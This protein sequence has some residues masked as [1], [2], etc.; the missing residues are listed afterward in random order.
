M[1]QQVC[2]DE[3]QHTGVKGGRGG[4]GRSEGQARGSQTEGTG[5]QRVTVHERESAVVPVMLR[6]IAGSVPQ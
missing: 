6:S 5:S 2:P 3:Q 4:H 1:E